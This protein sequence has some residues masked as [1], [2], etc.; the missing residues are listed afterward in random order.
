MHDLNL[1][2]SNNLTKI[3]PNRAKDDYFLLLL[4]PKIN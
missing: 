2:P 4:T 3:V 1:T